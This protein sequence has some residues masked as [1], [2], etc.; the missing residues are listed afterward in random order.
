MNAPTRPVD[1]AA[2]SSAL[3]AFA[4]EAWDRRIVPALVDYI[5]VPAVDTMYSMAMSIS[6]E[7]NR[8]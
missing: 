5:A 7:P 4:D 8:V 6:T 1:A 2:L 3:A